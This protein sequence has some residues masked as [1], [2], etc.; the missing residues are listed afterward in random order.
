[1]CY[2]GCVLFLFYEILGRWKLVKTLETNDWLVMNS[3]I[4]KIYTTGD[5]DA[6]RTQFLEQIK[7]VIDFDSADFYLASSNEKENLERP[8]FLNC[9]EDLSDIYENMD[10]SR[11]IMFSGRS[12]VYRE[13]DI[14]SDE[15]RV[16]TEY[17]QRVYKP[18]NWHYALQMIFGRNKHFLG[19]V[20]LYRTIGKEDFTYEDV[21]LMDMLKDHMAYR[22]SQDR[23]NQMTSQEKLTL[24]QA[25]KTYD[26]TKREQTILQL[27]L[28]GMENTE[29]CDHLSITVNTL[30]KHILNIYRK[31]GIRNRV[32]M[33][34]LI[35]EKE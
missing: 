27:L 33:F 1:M 22:L 13:T 24:T 15:K 35:K 2:I 26:L 30:K 23:N 3:I 19:V 32:Q 34:K 14:I 28:Q 17:Y 31:L 29:I 18:N 25:V 8:V 7:T 20:T 16:Q 6:M 5:F 12:M 21:F 11:G 10:Y 4:Y 9:D